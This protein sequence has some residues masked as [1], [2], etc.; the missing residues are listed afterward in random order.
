MIAKRKPAP[1]R[2]R[3]G[4]TAMPP[5][6]TLAHRLLWVLLLYVVLLLT[7]ALTACADNTTRS[8]KRSTEP[9]PVIACGEHQPFESLPAYPP[10][11]GVDNATS[12]RAYS[13]AQSEWAVEAAGVAERNGLKRRA[14]ADCLDAYR[15]RG[16]IL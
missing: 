16:V 10:A 15:R 13:A 7:L 11:P 9:T 3:Y 4:T 8:S 14:T 6:K 1:M 5:N 12:L 2:R